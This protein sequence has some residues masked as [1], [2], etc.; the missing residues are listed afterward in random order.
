MIQGMLFA[1]TP[2]AKPAKVARPRAKRRPKPVVDAAAPVSYIAG[3][4]EQGRATWTL[5]FPAPAAMISVNGN[6]HWRKTSPAR[7]AFREAMFVHAKAAK[8]PVGLA[9]VRVD[10]VLRFPTNGRRDEGNYHNNVAKPLVDAIGPAINAVRGGKPVVAPGLGVIPDDTAE[11][12][13]GPFLHPGPK[14]DDPKRCPFGQVEV[15]ITD[16]SGGAVMG[17]PYCDRQWCEIIPGLFMGGHD[18]MAPDGSICDVIVGDEFGLVLSLYQRYGCGPPVGVE[19]RYGRIPDGVLNADDLDIVLRFADLGA[20]AVRTGRRVL[21][22]CQAGYNRSGLLAAFILLR[23]GRG[24]DEAVELIR[25]RRSPFALCN[26]SFVALI[27]DEAKRLAVA[28]RPV[29]RAHA[30]GCRRVGCGRRSTFGRC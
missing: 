18:Y 6:P 17:V 2:T 9:R 14:V 10:I 5:T 28:S 16:L 26:E 25:T 27:H 1:D 22:R 29:R 11:F 12:L 24:A 4:D 13:D 7:K 8:V 20:E 3:A 15:T 23:L 30:V 19:R 21:S